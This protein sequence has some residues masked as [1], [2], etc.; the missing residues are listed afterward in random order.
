MKKIFLTLI[1]LLTA[2]LCFAKT[3]NGA[4]CEKKYT[5]YDG[6]TY[7]IAVVEVLKENQNNYK[8][9]FL[10][11]CYD[12]SSSRKLYGIVYFK[13]KE[14]ALKYY[15]DTMKAHNK[16]SKSF[17]EFLEFFDDPENNYFC[18]LSIDE[19]LNV[20]LYLYVGMGEI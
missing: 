7:G 8:W 6:T 12:N 9:S 13:S 19:E 17:D 1:L 4:E 15:L 2:S 3:K 10:L 5:H 18:E 20:P 11:E 14:A 16:K